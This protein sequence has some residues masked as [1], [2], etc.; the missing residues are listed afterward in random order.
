LTARSVKNIAGYENILQVFDVSVISRKMHRI[1][2]IYGNWRL[3][4]GH[5]SNLKPD[6]AGFLRVM[7][8]GLSRF[9]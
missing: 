8:K 2:F 9:Y 5:Y 4:V 7:N 1:T 6:V 3:T